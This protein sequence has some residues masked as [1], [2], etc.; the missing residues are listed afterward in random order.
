MCGL[1][2]GRH[3]S[4][5]V[6]K[7]VDPDLASTAPKEAPKALG[8]DLEQEDAEVVG[9]VHPEQRSVELGPVQARRTGPRVNRYVLIHLVDHAMTV[10]VGK[11]KMAKQHWRH[12]LI[13]ASG[14]L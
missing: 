10:Q 6:C 12:L 13:R 1:L 14:N 9:V 4:D 11:L 8:P 7:A 2:K 5:P 3:L